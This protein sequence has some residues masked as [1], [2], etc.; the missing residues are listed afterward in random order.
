MQLGYNNPQVQYVMYG[1]QLQCE[2]EE[3]NCDNV[4]LN[5]LG[6][7]VSEDLKCEKQCSQAV[8]KPI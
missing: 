4:K 1:E 5:N 8:K 2:T 6:V 7:I 3:C